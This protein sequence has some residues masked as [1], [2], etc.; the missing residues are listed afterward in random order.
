MCVGCYV[1]AVHGA[2]GEVQEPA[3]DAEGSPAPNACDARLE[4]EKS[5]YT[6]ELITTMGFEGV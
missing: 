2:R 6:Y 3:V 5:I 4:D 1:Q